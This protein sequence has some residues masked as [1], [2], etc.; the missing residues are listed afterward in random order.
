MAQQRG[1]RPRGQSRR[2]PDGP[3]V[4]R[5]IAVSVTKRQIVC[6]AFAVSSYGR[7]LPSSSWSTLRAACYNENDLLPA[8]RPCAGEAGGTRVKR[9]AAAEAAV[10]GVTR[11]SGQV[12]FLCIATQL[13]VRGLPPW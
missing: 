10:I 12:C 3:R 2:G 8:R 7:W 5:P 4:V 1:L 9:V 6:A 11:F 13:G